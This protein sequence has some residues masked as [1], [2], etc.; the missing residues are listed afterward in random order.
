MDLI[1]QPFCYKMKL[2]VSTILMIILSNR[3]AGNGDDTGCYIDFEGYSLSY[4]RSG[5]GSIL[6]KIRRIDDAKKYHR[7][8]KKVANVYFIG[9]REGQWYFNTIYLGNTGSAHVES[10][11]KSDFELED[12]DPGNSDANPRRIYFK[13]DCSTKYT[14]YYWPKLDLYGNESH[15]IYL[16]REED[17]QGENYSIDNF[18]NKRVEGIR[19]YES[20]VTDSSYYH[21]KYNPYNRNIGDICESLNQ[22]DDKMASMSQLK[23]DNENV[24]SNITSLYD[25]DDDICQFLYILEI[26]KETIIEDDLDNLNSLILNHNNQFEEYKKSTNN[27]R[28][29]PENYIEIKAKTT[30]LKGK[31]SKYTSVNTKHCI[32]KDRA[33]KE[34]ERVK[35]EI[36]CYNHQ[37]KRLVPM[38]KW[39]NKA[40][41][42]LIEESEGIT[43][44]IVKDN[45]PDIVKLINGFKDKGDGMEGI[46]EFENKFIQLRQKINELKEFEER[47]NNEIEQIIADLNT[48]RNSIL[49][50]IVTK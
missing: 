43:K 12:Y 27:P 36:S 30:E 24:I 19:L 10:G 40:I 22:I 47:Q 29:T 33:I 31:I 21:H 1:R 44:S 20:L 18:Y 34:E 38:D 26:V 7:S 50:A 9:N 6:S 15:S 41:D 2:I 25:L 3:V 49:S 8:F 39:D 13:G 45:L 37:T 32:D 42:H 11:D 23:T 16:F 28:S 5:A 48:K 46:V 4:K 35:E 14:R 17:I